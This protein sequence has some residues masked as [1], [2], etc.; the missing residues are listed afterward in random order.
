MDERGSDSFVYLNYVTSWPVT[1]ALVVP[2][3]ALVI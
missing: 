1:V 2:T 3:S